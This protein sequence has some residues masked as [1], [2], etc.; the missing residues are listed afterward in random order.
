MWTTIAGW[1]FGG[2]LNKLGQIGVDFYRTKLTAENTTEKHVADLAARAIDLD[3][4]EA[5]LNNRL[6]VTEEG[7]WATR[8]VRP[9]WAAPFVFYT[10][11]KVV[12]DISLGWMHVA[13]LHDTAS[14]MCVT[15]IV[16]Y[17]GSRG[18]EKLVDKWAMVRMVV[19]GKRS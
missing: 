11:C 2:G 17:F 4:R 9:A 15:I 14:T 12:F 13:E 5:E 16:S 8:W 18:L 19:T 6:L 3:Q 1:F 7:N 10:W